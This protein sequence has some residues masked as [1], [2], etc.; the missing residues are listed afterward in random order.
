MS[1]RDPDELREELAAIEFD[2]ESELLADLRSEARQTVA[3]QKETL[4]D[5]DAKASRIL[6]LNVLLIGVIVSAIS[7][8]GS[9]GDSTALGATS[10]FTNLYMKA[11]VGS[12][13]LSTVL[14]A[15][16]Y[17]ASELDVGVSSNNLTNLVRADLKTKKA[18][19]LL[20]KTTYTASTSTGARTYGTPR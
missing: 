19:K 14:S 1:S 12:L 4:D 10:S 9:S 20:V 13:V 17:T 2:G 5:I 16:T 11:G 3:A 6:R 8:A 15:I 18:R 7:I